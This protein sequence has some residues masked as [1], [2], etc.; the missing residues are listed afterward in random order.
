MKGFATRNGS[1]TVDPNQAW[2][3]DAPCVARLRRRAR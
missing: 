1:R 2:D 3:D